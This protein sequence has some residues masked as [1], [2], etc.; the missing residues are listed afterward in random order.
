MP[1]LNLWGGGEGLGR[2]LGKR[3][4]CNG[5]HAET[6]VIKLARGGESA[7]AHLFNSLVTTPEHK[8]DELL[9]GGAPLPP[10]VSL[11]R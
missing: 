3:S 11:A 10:H 8:C 4:F 7:F 9:V 2:G 5:D 6:Q 1:L